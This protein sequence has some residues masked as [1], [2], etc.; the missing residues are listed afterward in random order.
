MSLNTVVKR[1]LVSV[2]DRQTF[3]I[4]GKIT[5]FIVLILSAGAGLIISYICYLLL[6]IHFFNSYNINKNKSNSCI[7]LSFLSMEGELRK[8][9]Y[10]LSRG[11]KG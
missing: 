6:A 11:E 7:K 8:T 1:L 3:F 10:I 4:G 5:G 9:G 2:N